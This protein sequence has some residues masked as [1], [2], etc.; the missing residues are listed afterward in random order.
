[1]IKLLHG[2][3]VFFAFL[4]PFSSRL[5]PIW[6]KVTPICLVGCQNKHKLIREESFIYHPG[7]EKYDRYGYYAEIVKYYNYNYNVDSVSFTSYSPYGNISHG[8]HIFTN[9]YGD[10]VRILFV[11]FSNYPRREE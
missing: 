9:E 3:K 1:M 4:T 7:D 2:R 8:I 5:T 11:D 6:K 10:T